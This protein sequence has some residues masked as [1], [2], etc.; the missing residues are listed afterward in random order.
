MYCFFIFWYGSGILFVS[1]TNPVAHEYRSVTM[2]DS[3]SLQFK[4]LG[5]FNLLLAASPELFSL[6][7]KKISY[8]QKKS[9]SLN[10]FG[11]N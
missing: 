2:Y 6:F 11:I 5:G 8:I 4:G 1:V 9:T 10:L 3:M 7:F